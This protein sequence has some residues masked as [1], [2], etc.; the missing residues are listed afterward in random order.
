MFSSPNSSS[1]NEAGVAVDL[2]RLR[3]VVCNVAVVLGTGTISVRDCLSLQ[4]GSL[5]PL[6][7]MAGSDLQVLVNGVPVAL[8]EVVI[9]DDSTAIRLTEILSPPSAAAAR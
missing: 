8:G 4:G 3:D 1:S 5:I 6:Q 7:Q 2:G 9:V